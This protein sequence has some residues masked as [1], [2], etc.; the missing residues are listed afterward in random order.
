MNIVVI[1]GIAVTVVVGVAAIICTIYYGRRGQ[2]KKLM[3]YEVSESIALARSF[4]PEGDYKISVL[5]QRKGS[6]EEKIES[7]YTTFL[8]F[9]NLGKEP[10]RGEDIAPSNPLRVSV[11]G[12][13]ILDIQLGGITR[14]VNNVCLRD[15]VFKKEQ[16][17]AYV[18]FDYLDYRDGALVKIVS[19]GEA[20][21]ISLE[22]DIIGMPEGINNIGEIRTKAKP[23][24]TGST[25]STLGFAA[26][27][28]GLSGFIY[29][30]IMG[31]FIS[32]SLAFLPYGI[33]FGVIGILMIID[34]VRLWA[35]GRKSFPKSLE[36]PKWAR[37]FSYRV[38]MIR[39]EIM[40]NALLEMR[41][42]IEEKR[43][44]EDKTVGEENEGSKSDGAV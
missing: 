31:G 3:V 42:K 10:I 38:G 20:G 12:A 4:S 17:S 11:K 41:M 9:A 21:N 43:D 40:R 18:N 35:R 34:D 14:E 36:L 44:V 26:A 2:R 25:W 13:R 5:F 16:A 30:W 39:A 32:V 33:L 27:S 8:K 19:V 37:P 23:T 15:R 7:V 6:I 28:F 29:Y 1:I 24:L 22:G